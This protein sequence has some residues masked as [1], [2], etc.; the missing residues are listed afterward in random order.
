MRQILYCF[1]L[2][3]SVQGQKPPIDSFAMANWN[4]VTTDD[5]AITNDGKYF[6]Y[7]IR[8]DWNNATSFELQNIANGTKTEIV[9]AAFCFFSDDSKRVVFEK[10]DSLFFMRL[11]TKQ[12]E[13]KCKYVSYKQPKSKRGTWLAYRVTNPVN[14]LILKNIC[15]N[16]EKRFPSVS[17][18]LF[19]NEGKTLLIKT[20]TKNDSCPTYSLKWCDL[21]SNKEVAIWTGSKCSTVGGYNFDAQGKQ[22]AFIEESRVGPR[23]TLWYYKCGTGKSVPMV[24]DNNT[25]LFGERLAISTSSPLFS[26]NGNYILFYTTTKRCEILT[27]QCAALHLGL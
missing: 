2:S 27:D 10:D 24:A 21:S 6:S 9:G 16:V 17:D 11:A 18:Y 20:A 3:L 13:S 15:T 1:F 22:L 19:D 23:R 26:D 12:V 25:S 7:K 8:N 5:A 4:Y 14:E